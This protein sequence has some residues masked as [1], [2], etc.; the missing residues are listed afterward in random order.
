MGPVM[1]GTGETR[2]ETRTEGAKIGPLTERVE[3]RTVEKGTVTKTEGKAITPVKA[4]KKKLEEGEK[5]KE[6][7][8]EEKEEAGEDE[9]TEA[10]AED[11]SEK[12][13]KDE[14]ELNVGEEK[15]F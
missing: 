15:N 2:V 11:G 7:E 3:T 8:G 10:K 6:E 4:E 13:E 5:K 9:K 12:K 14:G 1:A